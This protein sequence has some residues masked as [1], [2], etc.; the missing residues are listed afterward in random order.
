MLCCANVF[1]Q[2]L[3]LSG[4]VQDADNK[5]M[6]G[7]N[8]YIKEEE[9]GTITDEKGRYFFELPQGTYEV[10]FSMVGYKQQVLQLTLD[11]ENVQRNVWMQEDVVKMG[12]VLVQH[13]K[14]DAS[15]EYIGNAIK[16]RNKYKNLPPYLSQDVYI[17]SFVKK[18]RDKTKKQQKWE[19]EWDS[20]K[21]DSIQKD[22]AKRAANMVFMESNSRLHYKAPDQFKEI[23]NAYHSYGG[24]YE[25]D[26]LYFSKPSDGSFNFYEGIIES[27]IT[28]GFLHSPI[29]PSAFINYRYKLLGSRYENNRVIYKIQ[30]KP[31]AASNSVF[32]GTIEIVDSLWLI[33]SVDLSIA[34]QALEQ[35]DNFNIKQSYT[36]IN[37]TLWVIDEQLFEYTEKWGKEHYKGRTH[38][39]YS[40]FDANP[41]FNKKFF[42][43]ELRATTQDA[44]DRDSSYW[45][46]TRPKELTP[47]EQQFVHQKDSLKE[48]LT[49]ESFLDS[50]DE[51]FNKIRLLNV[52]YHGQGYA[53]RSKLKRWYF[54]SLLGMIEPFGVGGGRISY[55]LSYYKRFE[56]RKYIFVLPEIN[57]GPRNNNLMGTIYASNLYSPF[58]RGWWGVRTGRASEFINEYDA[59]VNRFKRS[60]FYEKDFIDISH[61]RELFN[62]F[63]F[64]QNVN[65]ASRRS[66]DHFQFGNNIERVF[67]VNDPVSFES[68][69]A[70]DIEL[71]F[72][73]TPAQKYLREP[74]EKVIL[75][76]KYPKFGIGIQQ[77][78]PGLFGSSI[79]YTELK[80]LIA[81][82]IK[83]GVFGSSK[84][85]ILS[86]KFLNTSDLKYIDSRFHQGSDPYVF[87]NPM[88]TFQTLRNTYA[89]TDWFLDVH[90]MH[91]FNGVIMKKFPLIRK[92]RIKSVAGSAF[93]YTLEN[94]QYHSEAFIGVER[95]FKI[96]KEKFRIG[97]YWAM[98]STNFENIRGEYKMSVEFYSRKDRKWTY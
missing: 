39:Y 31:R 67:D 64:L 58:H 91:H 5:P 25:L 45:Q 26:R 79:N 21:I 8:I 6:P 81:Q 90:Y 35:Y 24:E 87:T 4:Y 15:Y 51:D 77:G 42:N 50:L 72:T 47:K 52:V 2:F 27:E 11:R 41:A 44:Y 83:V 12:E 68:Y 84:Y 69:K 96:F 54:S 17:K 29:G 46:L 49:K 20:L 89:T 43:N 53:K 86:G 80:I 75:G 32:E 76:S 55:W 73:Y 85:R 36:Q 22:T 37:D 7:V 1:G 30:V 94:N 65:Y 95:L 63:F 82:S 59:F 19:M 70:F 10:V 33:K 74:N 34:K 97:A 38:V 16:S 56:N 61:Y 14:R 48:L 60:N 23:R 66:V 88:L 40:N 62:G 93:L 9:A 18:S 78:V 13:K 71:F 57:Y 28:S 92:T 98:G 3:Q